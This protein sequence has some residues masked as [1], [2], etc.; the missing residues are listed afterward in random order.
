MIA[1]LSNASTTSFFRD[2][3]EPIAMQ[4]PPEILQES[5]KQSTM[6]V[7]IFLYQWW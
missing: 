5:E 6:V 1:C 3:R 4:I 7:R 2:K